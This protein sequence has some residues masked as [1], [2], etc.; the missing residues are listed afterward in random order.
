MFIAL[1][2]ALLGPWV[3]RN[4]ATADYGG[5]SSFA[6]D[7]VFADAVPELLL[8]VP[9]E[10]AK[11]GL[12]DAASAR[13]YMQDVDRA[14]EGKHGP[15]TPGAAARFR[16]NYSAGVIARHRWTYAK[17]HA[18]GA[19]GFFLPGATDVLEIAG[20]SHGQRGASDVL[21]R[22]GVIAAAKFYFSDT[23][24]PRWQLVVALVLAGAIVLVTAAQ[25]LGAILLVLRAALGKCPQPL[26]WLFVALVIIASLLSGPYG[27][28]RYQTMIVPLLSVLA[29][30]GWRCRSL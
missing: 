25:Y 23:S 10:K 6:S 20:L 3:L 21:R 12:T 18:K 13:Q 5:F 2:A 1:G 17:L 29:A 14:D 24:I 7:S 28:P 8:N 16:R 22:D 27:F 30:A 9:E 11:A 15:R 19:I 26:A 4:A